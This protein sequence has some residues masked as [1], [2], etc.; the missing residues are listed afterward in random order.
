MASVFINEL[1]Y[2]NDGTDAGEFVEIAGPAGTDLTGWSLVLYNGSSTSL[3]PYQTV[4]L[5]GVL[6]DA[7]DGFGFTVV[8]TPGLQNGSP[9]GLALVNAGGD[10]V[11]FLSYEGTFV[12]AGGAADG[13]LSTDIGVEEAFDTPLGFSLQRTG[14]GSRS[15]DFAFVAP[16]AETPGAANTGQTFVPATPRFIESFETAPGTT[17]TL[18]ASFDDGQFDFFGRYAVPDT[19]NSAR[20]DFAAGWDGAFGIIGQDHDGDGQAATQVITVANIDI[21]GYADPAVALLLGALD[22]EPAFQ[23]YEAAAGDGIEIYATI[24]GGARFLIGAFAPNDDAGDLRQDTDLDGIGDGAVLTT[25]LEEFVFDLPTTGNLLTVEIELTSTDSFEALAVDRLAVDEADSFEDEGP[26]DPIVATIAEIQGDDHVSPFVSDEDVETFVRNNPAGATGALVTTTGIVT[27]ITAGGVL[28]QDAP[29]GD[30]NTSDAIFVSLLDTAGLAV[31][32]EL[33]VTGVVREVVD[34]S[35]ELP[36]TILVGSETTVLSSGNALPDA[37]DISGPIPGTVFDDDG[38]LSFD[39]TTDA[40]DFFESLEGMRVTVS[41][42]A[43]AGTNGFGELNLIGN[44]NTAA[45]ALSDRGTLNI[46]PDDFN[47]ERIQVSED[48]ELGGNTGVAVPLVDTGATVEV[49]GI[50]T[51]DFGNVQIL[52]TEVVVTEESTLEAE[53]SALEGSADKLS[54]ATYNVLNLDPN[55]DDGDTDIAD[56]RFDSIAQ[57]IIANL[58]SPDVIALQ[59]IQDNSGEDD[60]GTVSADETLMLL[61]DAIVAAGGP[62]YAY[63]DNTFIT[64]GESGGAP[65]ANI[66]TAFLY[67]PERVSLVDGSVR[68]ISDQQPGSAFAGA[69][70]PLVAT[71]EFGGEEV[72]L[73]NNHFSSKGG[74]APISGIEQPFADLQEDPS[75]NGSLNERRVQAQAVNDYVDGLLADD[76]D[77]NVV[78]LGDLN[79]FEFVSPLG[80][81]EGTVESA[82][83]GFDTVEGGAAVLSNLIGLIDEDERYSFNFQ[84]NSQQLD[85]ILVSDAL[86][87]GAE[88]DIVHVNTEFAETDERASDHDP[89][90][91]LLELGGAELTQVAVELTPLFRLGSLARELVNGEVVDTHILFTTRAA[92]FTDVG[93]TVTGQAPG[94]GEVL[95]FADGALGIRMENELFR[96]GGNRVE[97][98]EVLTIALDSDAVGGTIELAEVLRRKEVRV[99]LFDDGNIV[100]A[101]IVDASSGSIAIAAEETPFDTV[102]VSAVNRSAFSIREFAFTLADDLAIA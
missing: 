23:N 55:E 27:A 47:P 81:L 63:I 98:R 86:L 25:V 95:N 40:L 54:V 65:G 21:S 83:N 82:D 31:G 73:V 14:T 12:A 9:D 32:D 96:P 2:D 1:H 97:G 37:V 39:R 34:A 60:D 8:L 90:L 99:E 79:E 85:H 67:N 26:V 24:D 48:W 62:Q 16:G 89:V 45:G 10:V 84:G 41:G 75:V 50:I 38:F 20:D 71:F 93:I 59:E 100:A 94:R 3:A 53:V 19:A 44:G 52:P 92:T 13:L 80:I 49:E 28:I 51:Y 30:D 7:G 70:L 15:Q 76:A 33:S 72:T 87:G 56:G 17:Y 61:I 4:P 58:N 36:Q 101:A 57:Q 88:V 6:A 42:T 66:R 35:R 102:E 68:T 69:R 11:E 91:A 5:S 74:S 77:A 46:G 18:S 29:D 78:V 22:D 43:V 64:D